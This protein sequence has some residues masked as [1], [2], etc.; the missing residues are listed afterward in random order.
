MHDF[1]AGLLG[2]SIWTGK[3]LFLSGFAKSRH[4]KNLGFAIAIIQKIL[5]PGPSLTPAVN[6]C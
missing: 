1:L 2:S 3:T 6:L 4:R 5:W